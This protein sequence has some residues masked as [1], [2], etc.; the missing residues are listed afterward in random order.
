M[1][2]GFRPQAGRARAT[3]TLADLMG[4]GSGMNG[5]WQILQELKKVNTRLDVIEGQVAEVTW[6]KT[7]HG[8]KKKLS[9]VSKTRKYSKLS[10]SSVNETSDTSDEDLSRV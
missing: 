8:K 7:K 1:L 4:D 2:R 6:T 5:Q 9:T 10:D 3:E